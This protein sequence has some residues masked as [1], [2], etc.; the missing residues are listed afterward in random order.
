MCEIALRQGDARGGVATATTLD[1]APEHGHPEPAG[2][3]GEHEGV[4]LG[5]ADLPVGS[6]ER[7]QPGVLQAQKPDQQRQGPV[8]VKPDMLEEALQPTV[9]RGGLHRSGSLA[10]KMAEVHAARADH[11]DDD[12]AQGLQPALAEIDLRAQNSHEGGHGV[13]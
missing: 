5:P 6:V 9:C 12:Q 1:Q 2:N 11:A 3:D 10:G 8:R 7:Q 4:H 13:V